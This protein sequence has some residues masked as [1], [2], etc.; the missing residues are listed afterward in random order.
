MEAMKNNHIDLYDAVKGFA[1]FLVVLGHA[2]AWQFNDYS[3][4]LSGS[5]KDVML[6]WRIIYSFHMPLFFFCSGLFHDKANEYYSFRNSVCLVYK[7]FLTL[8]IP[9]FVTGSI[10]NIVSGNFRF[11]WFLLTLFEFVV[12]SIVLNYIFAKIKLLPNLRY[13]FYGLLIMTCPFIIPKIYAHECLPFIDIHHFSL[14]PYFLLGI[15]CHRF[16]VIEKLCRANNQKKVFTIALV[17]FTLFVYLFIIKEFKLPLMGIIGYGLPM[18]AFVVV[19]VFLNYGVNKETKTYKTLCNLGVHSLEIYLLHVFFRI[20]IPE[21]GSFIIRNYDGL[22]GG[23][24]CSYNTIYSSRYTC[25]N[26]HIF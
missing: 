13:F 5:N 12:F 19:L 20:Q 8:I 10:Y 22:G 3:L 26:S 2:I 1:I 17:S 25:Y 23:K 9:Y 24:I 7:R 11:Y 21:I 15:I 18:S 6:L 4:V 16:H 14:L